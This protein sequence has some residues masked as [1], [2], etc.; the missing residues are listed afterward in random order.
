MKY[1]TALLAVIASTMLAGPVLAQESSNA[2]TPKPATE[3]A[4][5]QDKDVKTKRG[6]I[7]LEKFSR[8][9]ELKA[10][11]TNGD[12][13]LSRDE[14]EALALKRFVKREAD[15]LERRLDVKGDGNITLTA[16]ENQRKKEFAALDRNEDGKLD[17][18]EMR[19]AH[20]DR[21]GKGPHGGRHGMGQHHK[22]GEKG[23]HGPMKGQNEKPQE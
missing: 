19:A 13:T 16:I 4:A 12:G 9:E 18:S 3:A 6:P 23:S 2:N 1:R 7:D 21:R 5:T 22:G 10:A 17:R 15:R 8:M 14:I 11:D 20:M